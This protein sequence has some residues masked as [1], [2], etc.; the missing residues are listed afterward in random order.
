M[1]AITS[2]TVIQDRDPSRSSSM[3]LSVFSETLPPM[4]AVTTLALAPHATSVTICFQ[5]FFNF[6]SD[7]TQNRSPCSSKSHL[8]KHKTDIQCHLKPSND[9]LI[10]LG[11][12]HNTVTWPTNTHWFA[13]LTFLPSSFSLPLH[14]YPGLFSWTVR[15]S[16]PL[17]PGL[18]HMLFPVSRMYFLISTLS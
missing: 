14:S 15:S 7:P 3:L 9:F 10:S 6:Q 2:H 18:L 5:D 12:S 1:N 4:P 16:F 11:Q 13:R 17:P 8:L